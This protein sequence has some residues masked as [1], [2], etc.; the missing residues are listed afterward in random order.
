MKK[1]FIKS[2]VFLI[3]IVL[4]FSCSNKETD[5][6]KNESS[7]DSIA[8][9]I[10]LKTYLDIVV[11][12]PSPTFLTNLFENNNIPYDKKLVLEF[13]KS[14]LK[15][16]IQHQAFFQGVFSADLSYLNLHKKSFVSLSYYNGVKLIAG[17]LGVD[18]FYGAE[19]FKKFIV[20]KNNSEALVE[21]TIEDFVLMLDFLNEKNDPNNLALMIAFGAWLES[22]YILSETYKYNDI[23]EFKTILLNQEVNLK[24]LITLFEVSPQSYTN[25]TFVKNLKNI[26]LVYSSLNLKYQFSKIET[27]NIN[28]QIFIF[29]HYHTNQEM[30]KNSLIDLHN[31]IEKSRNNLIQINL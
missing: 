11:T 26:E 6:T 30:E 15:T 13:D 10:S 24:R 29:E 19:R 25:Q 23:K 20:N 9:K 7:T 1:Y 12:T 2:F 28:N 3:S 17:S 21:M 14:L 27:K 8:S 18:E 5:I 4:F 16:S 31:I 22:L